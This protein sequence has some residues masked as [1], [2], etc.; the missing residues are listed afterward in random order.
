MIQ[1]ETTVDMMMLR[2]ANQYQGLEIKGSH[3]PVVAVVSDGGNPED[4]ECTDEKLRSVD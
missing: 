2:D 3:E 1:L 4:C